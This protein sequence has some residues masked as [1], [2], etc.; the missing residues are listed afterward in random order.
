[1]LDILPSVAGS[2][3]FEIQIDSDDP[4]EPSVVLYGEGVA[5]AGAQPELELFGRRVLSPAD[6]ENAG[7]IPSGVNTTFLYEARNAGSAPLTVNGSVAIT[8]VVN[9]VVVLSIAPGA[10][11]NPGQM[12]PFGIDVQ[13]LTPGPFQF[14][15]ELV[16]SDAD[17]S[18]LQVNVQGQGTAALVPEIA[19]D[20]DGAAIADGGTDDLQDL[21][22]SVFSTFVYRIRNEGTSTLNVNSP[23][24]VF[25]ETGCVVRI[26]R[27]PNAAVAPQDDTDVLVG[28]MPTGTG[29]FSAILRVDSNDSNEGQY[30]INL[31]GTGPQPDIQVEFPRFTAVSSGSI[32]QVGN[33]TSGQASL[34]TLFVRNTG[35]GPLT[36][37]SVT[38][39]VTTNVTG[40]LVSSG[41]SPISP[42]GEVD[43]ILTVTPTANGP[44][45]IT[46]TIVSNDP[47]TGNFDITI[48]GTGVP[49]KNSGGDG[50]DDSSCSTG[51]TT[52]A[53]WLVMLGL[54]SAIAVS[55]RSA[56]RKA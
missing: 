7:L 18:P 39:S 29:A 34:V 38:P 31:I 40:A 6:T 37:T 17:E 32:V 11:V 24:R 55:I 2:F 46:F 28:V 13:P 50:G 45:S 33:R 22:G 12:T 27:M 25:G 44:W 42:N 19:L 35:T 3:S 51:S 54:L 52:G 47:D 26:L 21:P 36:I 43:L 53:G 8:G 15:F 14:D 48:E 10:T 5:T 9:A 4:D 41:A 20:R 16:T 56:R 30:F 49:K 1:V 23:V